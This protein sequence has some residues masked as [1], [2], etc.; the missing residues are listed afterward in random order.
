MDSSRRREIG[1]GLGESP[2]THGRGKVG[3]A[4]PDGEGG[5]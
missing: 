3:L 4:A 1:G 5:K 2:G